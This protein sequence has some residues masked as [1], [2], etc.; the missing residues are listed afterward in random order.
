MCGS[1]LALFLYVYLF[2]RAWRPLPSSKRKKCSVTYNEQLNK[3]MYA[4]DPLWQLQIFH[5]GGCKGLN[6][7][8]INKFNM[9]YSDLNCHN[10][11]VMA[12]SQN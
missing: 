10:E 12:H 3:P 2:P 8:N 1:L 9:D 11:R 5:P 7:Q 6:N 4:K